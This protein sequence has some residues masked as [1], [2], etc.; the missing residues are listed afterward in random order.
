VKPNFSTAKLRLSDKF[1]AAP[2]DV[3]HLL[4]LARTLNANFIG[5][6]FHVGSQCD[7]LETM[8]AAIQYAS[9]LKIKAG[10]WD[11]KSAF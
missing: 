3:D 5:F 8:R 7:D 11:S 1:G 9:E 2:E 10:R 4:Q 6:S